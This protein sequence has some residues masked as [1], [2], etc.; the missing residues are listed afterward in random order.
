[1]Q[2]RDVI[3]PLLSL[4]VIIFLWHIASTIVNQPYL[5]PPPENVAVAFARLFFERNLC[6]HMFLTLC[7]VLAGF[8]LGVAL[9]FLIGFLVSL[10]YF[11][12]SS[13]Y[14]YIV[15]VAVTPS[16]AF[17]PLLMLWI[18]LNDLL[19]IVAIMICV[20]FPLTYSIISSMKNLDPEIIGVA[21]TLGARRRDLVLRII[22]PLSLTHVASALKIE[23]GHGWRI[24]FITEYLA[25]STGLGAL[26][27]FS[28]ATLR[29]DEI[30]ALIIIIG[31]L[32]LGF[33]LVI[34]KI[35]SMITRK[36]GLG[37]Q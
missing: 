30:I 1:M 23:A 18:G 25:L 5:F 9:G 8:I 12:R 32:A 16:I 19:P 2:L 37:K 36:W 10:N 28:Y 11:L 17:I 15:F 21:R 20:A 27:Y 35:E 34:E 22:L 7:R 13:L 31:V 3:A 4:A 24:G 14:P 29:V 6:F 33:Q 26:M